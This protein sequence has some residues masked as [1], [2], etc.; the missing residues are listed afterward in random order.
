VLGTTETISGVDGIVDGTDG[1]NEAGVGT[2]DGVTIYPPTK[3]PLT[4]VQFCGK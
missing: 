4:Q 1:S 3:T 2:G